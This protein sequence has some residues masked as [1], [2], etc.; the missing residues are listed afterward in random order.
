MALIPELLEHYRRI[1]TARRDELA[2]GSLRAESE[3]LEQSDPEPF[4]PADRATAGSAKDE[5]LEDA[6][7]GTGQLARIDDALRRIEAGTY[8]ICEVCGRVIPVSRLD[9]VPWASLC[10]EDQETA[11]RRH[12]A[13]MPLGGEPSRVA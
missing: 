2:I 11:D 9:A 4:D 13:A 3:S 12:R 1:L 8:G 7:R 6:E 10:L 5:L